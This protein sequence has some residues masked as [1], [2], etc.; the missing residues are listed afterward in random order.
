MSVVPR[1]QTK[2]NARKRKVV[3]TRICSETSCNQILA[4]FL[5]VKSATKGLNVL[6][7]PFRERTPLIAIMVYSFARI[8]AVIQMKVGDY[9][10]QGRRR[11]VRLHEK[12]GKEHDVPCHHSLDQCLHDY[13]EAAGITDDVDGYLF[14]SARRKTGQLTT[15]PLFQQDAQPHHPPARESGWH[16]NADWQLYLPR[17]RHSPPI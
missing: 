1:C 9:F 12:G 6:Y 3:S 7:N 10:V 14:R 2:P 11:W 5:F 4:R 15:N 17:D 13:I 8:G 16:R